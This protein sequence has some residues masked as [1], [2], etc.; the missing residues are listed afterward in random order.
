MYTVEPSS[1]FTRPYIR[2]HTHWRLPLGSALLIPGNT[3][4]Q[5]SRPL[6]S[7]LLISGCTHTLE[8]SSW[9]SS[10]YTRQHMYTVEPSSWFT[11]PYIRLHTHWKLPLGSA[12]LIPGNTCTQLSRPLGSPLLISGCTHTLEASSWFSSPYTRQHIYTVEPSSWFT[13]PYIRL[14]THIGGFLLVQPSLYQATHTQWSLPL[15]SAPLIP[16]STH[17]VELSSWFTTPYTRQHTPSGAFLF[18][19]L[20]LYQ[21]AHTQWSLPLSSAPL[22]LRTT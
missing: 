4:T 6:G 21:A 20:P 14:Y 7:P 22:N 5:L 19:Q 18:V 3:C 16:G 8:A 15:C 12:L 1:W 11:R 10:P 2:L 17:T 9:F 13:P